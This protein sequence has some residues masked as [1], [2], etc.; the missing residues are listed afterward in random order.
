M[1]FGLSAFGSFSSVSLCP[2]SLDSP[3]SCDRAQTALTQN[4]AEGFLLGGSIKFFVLFC[5]VQLPR[6]PKNVQNTDWPFG[7][8]VV[9]LLRSPRSRCSLIRLCLSR[10][11]PVK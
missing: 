9:F 5:T 2:R 6:R 4:R 10:P 7:E 8:I 1:L 11:P 3:V